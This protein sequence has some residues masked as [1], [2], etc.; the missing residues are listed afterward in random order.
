MKSKLITIEDVEILLEAET[1][2]K[3]FI[4]HDID[5]DYIANDMRFNEATNGEFTV[6]V[7]EGPLELYWSTVNRKATIAGGIY[8]EINWDN[9]EKEEDDT[10]DFTIKM[11]RG[12]NDNEKYFSTNEVL[13]SRI[14]WIRESCLSP[15]SYNEHFDTLEML[16]KVL[17]LVDIEKVMNNKL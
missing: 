11:G 16:E 14:Q 13:Y 3:D 5:K 2:T 12:P 17:E 8:D 10:I 1:A 15:E 7:E 6:I 4:L 9:W